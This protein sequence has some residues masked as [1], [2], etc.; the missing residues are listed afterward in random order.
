MA[1]PDKGIPDKIMGDA[2]CIAVVP[3]MLKIA[4]DFGGSQGKEIASCRLENGK[5]SAVAPVMNDD[6]IHHLLSS[7]FKIG[8]D[9]SAA[10][11]PLGRHAGADTDWNMKS[12]V[13]TYSRSRAC[14]RELT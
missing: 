9:A 10:A 4:V 12:E 14:L 3:S 11:G 6:G 2:K 7:K 13:L 1:T 8:A 5:W